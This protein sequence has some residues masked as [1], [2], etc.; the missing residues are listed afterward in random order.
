MS[1]TLSDAD[2]IRNKRLAKLAS[3][4]T[5]SRS[6][7]QASEAS[8]ASQSQPT[9]SSDRQIPTSPRP[10][11]SQ[12]RI[13][14]NGVPAPAQSASQPETYET[15]LQGKRIK[16]SPAS[17]AAVS[18]RS[19][20][21]SPLPAK[22]PTPKA[23]E[24]VEAFEDRT[25]RAIFRVTLREDQQQDIHGHKLTY[26]PGVRSELEE[27]GLEPRMTVGVLDQAIVEAASKT[28]SQKPLNYLLPCWKR[29]H[30]LYKGFRK[31][32]D[33]DP[34]FNI[35]R[36]AR[37]LCIS[38]CIFAIT[39]PE[40]FGVESSS[41]SPL[42]P[43]LLLDAEDDRGI[44]FDFLSEAVKRFEEDDSLKPA[45]ITTVEEMSRDLSV[46]TINDDYKPYVTALRNLVH[47][48]AI[49]SAITE[50]SIFNAS[51]DPATFEQTTLLGPWFR[52]SPL[53]PSVTTT[54][55][56][57]PKTRD[58]TFIL[59]SQRSLRMTQ[60]M[61]SSD[62]LDVINHLI[63]A[64]KDARE[65][66][67]DWFATALNLNHKRRAMQV[68]PNTVSSDGFMFNITTCLDQLCEPFM[69]ASFTKIDRIDAKYLHRNPRVQM[70]DETKINA[71]QHASDEFYSKTVE[72]TSN[73]ITE[74]F[75]LT[76]AAHHY[77]SESLTS[78]L[79]QLEKDLRHMEST[80]NKFELERHKWI[81][82]PVQLRTFEEAL[83]R[84]KDKLDLGLALKYSLQGVLFDDLWQTR[85]MQ[86]MRYVIV[87]LLRLVS[88]VDFPRQKLTLP[89]PET[90]PDVFKCLP[91]YF[92]DDIVSNF[93]FIMWCM[94]QIITATQGDELVMLCISFLESSQYIK[95]PYLKAGLVSILFRGTWPR[96]GGARGV[97][98]DLLNSMPFATQ[99]LLHAIMKFYI[100]AEFTGTH[101][102]FFDK[103]NIRYEIFQIIKC[104][105][106][107]PVYRSQLSDQ[108]QQNLDFFV[109]FVNLLL[110]DVTFVLDESFT[111]FMTIH[112]TQVLLN[113][114]GNTM[115]P[116]TRQEK[117]E[118]LAAAQNKAK[119]YMQLTN[120]TV[121]MLKLFTE[122]LA[123][124]F[125]MPEIVQ[126]LADMLDYNLDAMVGPKSSNLR[127]ENLQEY[128]FNPRALLSEIVD[129][130]L[131]L[132]DKE[133]FTFA[134]ARDGRSYK[135]QNFEKAAD[136][137][138]KWSLKSD[139]D[140][141]KWAELQKRV[142][143]A[144]EADEQA[145]EDLGEIP[146]EF[147]DPLIYTLM[148]DPVI[149][150]SSKVSIDRSTIQSHLL[151]DPSDPFNRAPLKI[152]D[153]IPN[154]ELKEKIEAFKAERRAA[155]KKAVSESMDTSSG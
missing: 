149:L 22:R 37:R 8:E 40:M 154:T 17:S 131:N 66:V 134:V 152:E 33:E 113:Q 27:Q 96:P 146:D 137:L 82:N 102:Q 100:E 75:F 42:K 123:D 125:T 53:Q 4:V 118:Q 86:F 119:S 65:R 145:E 28:E 39:M 112:D 93:K 9:P 64:S 98:V 83:K 155:K 144:K 54:Y 67:L 3:Q 78:K 109:R 148:E 121:A 111:A 117:E 94:P 79:E 30:R 143:A 95:N 6:P 122:A 68:D 104:I 13:N 24:S 70:R 58:Q 48:A 25:L 23:E 18:P 20:S 107:N 59:N 129:V 150:P 5:S 46:M 61:L 34:K 32:Q 50:S 106:G 115:D 2:K 63:R 72:G 21:S 151:S 101:T 7:S 139:E 49:G 12:P 57:S 120:E 108:A 29:I 71:D 92:L 60:Q 99:Y 36:E 135:P 51:R 69:D 136:I 114:E 41:Q 87:W 138:R 55:F 44:D 11:A 26:L 128:G 10:E 110:N 88:G 97:L 47:H 105:W 90:P 130:Y 147:L 19:E 80:I 84:Y 45:F 141:R 31:T 35:V 1:D 133:N 38:Y 140:L 103:F 14:I 142:K 116:N 76:V 74:I 56:S 16:I 52:L 89:L 43:H 153:V 85:S 81:H 91:E 15:G 73:F 132:M 77:G 127:V 62:L 126:R 124:S